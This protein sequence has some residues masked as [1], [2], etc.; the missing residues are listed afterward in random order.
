MGSYLSVVNNTP[1]VWLCKVGPDEAALKIAGI[2]IAVIGTVATVIAT[3]GAAAPIAAFLTANGVVSVFGI[4]TGALAAVTSAAASVSTVA[5]V[6]G[7]V[8]GFGMSVA[9]GISSQ[10]Q[11]KG[12][13]SI[14]AGQKATWGK[15]TLS[16]WQQS[17]C[18]KTIIADPKTVRTETV[19]MR[20]IFSGSLAN[21]NRDHDIQWWVNK[22][23]VEVKTVQGNSGQK[24]RALETMDDGAEDQVLLIYPNGTITDAADGHLVDVA[25]LEQ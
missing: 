4:S 10:L 13:K 2:I 1:D 21:S 5:T 18:T 22:N 24:T 19:Y 23:G 7:S 6:I 20:P 3:A 9:K 15:M 14:P 12:Y 8:S 16:L 17:V 25:T 11:E